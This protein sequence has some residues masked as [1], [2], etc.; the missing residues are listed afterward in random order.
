MD[1][2]ALFGGKGA[3]VGGFCAQLAREAIDSRA[4]SQAAQSRRSDGFIG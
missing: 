1:P 4:T 3:A 2:C